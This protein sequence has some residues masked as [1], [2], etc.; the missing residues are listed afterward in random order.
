MS[1]EIRVVSSG[2][3]VLVTAPVE[4]FKIDSEYGET[5][6][7]ITWSRGD[8]GDDPEGRDALKAAWIGRDKITLTA[9][10]AEVPVFEGVLTSQSW[11]ED[12]FTVEA[13]E[14]AEV[15][16]DPIEIRVLV[17]TTAPNLDRVLVTVDNFGEGAVSLDFGDGSETVNNPGDGFNVSQHSYDSTGNFVIVATDTDQPDRT[18]QHVVHI[19]GT[20]GEL[21]VTATAD[22]T[23]PA[24]LRVKVTVDNSGEGPVDVDFG[25]DTPTVTNPGDGT[26]ESVHDYQAPGTYTVTTTDTDRPSRTGTADVTVVGDGGTGG[27]NLVVVIVA[28]ESDPDRKTASLTANNTTHGAT[29]ISWGDGSTSESYPGDNSVRTHVY[30]GEGTFSVVVTDEDEPARF[31]ETLIT[32]PFPMGS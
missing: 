11:C 5:E 32:L 16:A 23:D 2:E 3:S 26:T 15:P 7:C 29:T 17:D 28:D 22:D 30:V 20:A 25:D 27:D 9:E 13:A 8:L 1:Y 12:E 10:G 21:E 31:I 4:K 14:E 18:A 6:V 19:S 24:K